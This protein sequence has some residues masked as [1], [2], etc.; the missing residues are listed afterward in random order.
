M[1]RIVKNG[2]H[3]KQQPHR[4]Q[5]R[6]GFVILVKDGICSF[7]RWAKERS[8]DSEDKLKVA[9]HQMGEW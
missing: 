4:Q 9:V 7:T 6:T 3:E 2:R 5:D 8:T 1:L